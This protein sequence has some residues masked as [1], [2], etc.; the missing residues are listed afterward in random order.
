MYLLSSA[1]GERGIPA[2][3]SHVRS[4]DTRRAMV[5]RGPASRGCGAQRR[6]PPFNVDD[7]KT[8]LLFA[9]SHRSEASFGADW[10]RIV[11]LSSRMYI[12]LN[13]AHRFFPGFPLSLSLSLLI[14]SFNVPSARDLSKFRKRATLRRRTS[15][16]RSLRVPSRGFT[17]SS[18]SRDEKRR[19]RTSVS[20]R[21]S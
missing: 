1:N 13:F 2:H 3:L 21:D 12:T 17:R 5:F 9:T 20:S 4:A 10:S 19:S 18:D 7:G 8:R 14:R 16:P 11:S 15:A 6:Y